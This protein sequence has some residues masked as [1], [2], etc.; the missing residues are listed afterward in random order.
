ML[1]PATIG[2][3]FSRLSSPWRKLSTNSVSLTPLWGCCRKMWDTLLCVN[4]SRMSVIFNHCTKC[5]H[6]HMSD[7]LREGSNSLICCWKFLITSC[8]N[9]AL[10]GWISFADSDPSS[11]I[12][13]SPVWWLLFSMPS[14]SGN[15]KAVRGC[16]ETCRI[17]WCHQS[18]ISCRHFL[19]LALHMPKISR[20]SPEFVFKTLC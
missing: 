15:T 13:T 9:F 11:G 17:C 20:I 12:E 14:D 7:G 10:R 5:L 3:M 4:R 18:F 19:C 8:K 6:C 1:R 16:S 2:V